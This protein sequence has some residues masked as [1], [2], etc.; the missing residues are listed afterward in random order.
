[1]LNQGFETGTVKSGPFELTYIVEGTGRPTI[2]VGSAKYY[3][4]VFSAN[5][6]QRLR[7][8]F[9]DHR[10][11]TPSPGPVDSTAFALDTLIADI[12]RVRHHL[13]LEQV[14]V[15]GHSSHAYMA[16]E[17]AKASPEQ[18]SHVVM[19]GI[20]PDLSAASEEARIAYWDSF[21]SPERKAIQ[22]ENERRLPDDEIA[23]MPVS[24][25]R[26]FIATYIR[27]GPQAWYDA[28]F[29]ST[30]LWEGV[31]INMDMFDH[32]WGRVFR[33]ID[34][35]RHLDPLDRPVF[36]A[37]G[38]C[39]FLVA[40]PSI[41]DS[42]LPAFRDVTVRVFERSGHTPPFEEPELFDAELLAWMGQ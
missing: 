7:L 23:R 19:I 3:Q 13:R 38:R 9:V 21:A 8:V 1:M 17:Y 32:V 30:P 35:T 12:E 42:V 41:W 10:G 4:R 33:D 16:L 18:V 15:V 24:R 29:D 39:D 6:R 11:F 31:D 25:G 14:A 36:L 5:L 40:A 2:V 27:N 22:E 26:Q 34:I 37:L 28:N 20:S